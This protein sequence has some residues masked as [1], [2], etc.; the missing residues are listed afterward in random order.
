MYVQYSIVAGAQEAFRLTRGELVSFIG[1][2]C[3]DPGVRCV[4]VIVVATSPRLPLLDLI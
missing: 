3:I 1:H 4:F 2:D